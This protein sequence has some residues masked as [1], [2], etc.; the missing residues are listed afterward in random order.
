MK[1]EG[2]FTEAFSQALDVADQNVAEGRPKGSRIV[3]VSSREV[4]QK[5]AMTLGA[6]IKS[7]TSEFMGDFGDI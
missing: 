2:K 1:A 7:M 6:F 5:Q 4:N 3:E